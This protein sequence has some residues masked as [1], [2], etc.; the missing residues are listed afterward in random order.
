MARHRRPRRS[1]LGA[2]LIPTRGSQPTVA[3]RLEP[4]VDDVRVL[5]PDG[6]SIPVRWSR[7]RPGVYVARVPADALPPP[8]GSLIQVG[9]VRKVV[10]GVAVYQRGIA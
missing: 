8:H 3:A 5:Y 1:K 4:V 2:D 7:R 6:T 10:I 9:Q